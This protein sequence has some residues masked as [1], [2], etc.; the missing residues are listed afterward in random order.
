MQLVTC[1]FC[2]QVYEIER[3]SDHKIC[4]TKLKQLTSNR[5]MNIFGLNA[6]SDRRNDGKLFYNP[7]LSDAKNQ[8]IRDAYKEWAER[9]I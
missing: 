9:K 2:Y 5:K 4:R 7:H 6:A 3:K 8:D 1:K